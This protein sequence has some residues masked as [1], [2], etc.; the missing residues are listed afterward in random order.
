MG[1]TRW[2]YLTFV[3]NVGKKSQVKTYFSEVISSDRGP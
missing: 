2:L 1:S 3:A